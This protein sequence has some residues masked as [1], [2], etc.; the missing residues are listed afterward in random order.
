MV[1]SGLLDAAF[2][3]FGT[4]EPVMDEAWDTLEELCIATVGRGI[5]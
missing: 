5:A 1:C 2:R 4:A 3:A